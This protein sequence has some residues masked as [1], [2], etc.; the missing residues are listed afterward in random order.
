M[1]AVAA[2]NG[3]SRASA[4]RS[5]LRLSVTV[6]VRSC[7]SE[8]RSTAARRGVASARAAGRARAASRRQR[9]PPPERVT[10]C[11]ATPK[12]PSAPAIDAAAASLKRPT[13]ATPRSGPRRRRAA[14]AGAGSRAAPPGEQAA[15]RRPRGASDGE[16]PN[17]PDASARRRPCAQ[18]PLPA[19]T[20]Q[21]TTT[22]PAAWPRPAARTAS[23]AGRRRRR[24]SVAA[25]DDARRAERQRATLPSAS[26]HERARAGLAGRL[27]ALR[28]ER[29]AAVANERHVV[30]EHRPR[31]RA[32]RCH[33]PAGVRDARRGRADASAVPRSR[34]RT[35][36][37]RPRRRARASRGRPTSAADAHRRRARIAGRARL[38]ATRSTPA[39]TSQAIDGWRPSVT[40]VTI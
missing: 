8:A 40:L 35:P 21:A 33:A 26:V 12:R 14:H 16:P 32:R 13:C 27:L 3:P 1:P 30:R 23:A 39:H 22:V 20:R 19:T 24:A 25:V 5:V 18:H 11:S 28:D 36:A 7:R 9:T 4:S 15:S 29:E 6:S 17:G 2:W 31:Q 10:P 38:R 34:A 37:R